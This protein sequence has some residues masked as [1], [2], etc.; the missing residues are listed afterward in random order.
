LTIWATNSFRGVGEGVLC[1]TQFL[2]SWN[3]CMISTFTA[4]VMKSYIFWDNPIMPCSPL[5]VNR[6]FGEIC[7]LQIQRRR[8]SQ[9]RKQREAS[10]KRYVISQK[11]EFK[12]NKHFLYPPKLT[13][14]N[15]PRFS[16][17]C[18]GQVDPYYCVQHTVLISRHRA[19]QRFRGLMCQGST[20]SGGKKLFC[21]PQ[22]P[23]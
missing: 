3:L 17:P 5:E 12:A 4:V 8:I 1:F 15:L 13:L 20:S 23:D 16:G 14:T 22:R 18:E 2:K 21:S 19:W 9:S 10:S 6:R 11:I 7:E